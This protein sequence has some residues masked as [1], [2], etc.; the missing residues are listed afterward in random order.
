MRSSGI[1]FGAALAV[2]L[3]LVATASATPGDGHGGGRGRPGRATADLVNTGADEDASGRID[4]KHFPAVGRRVER[5]WLRFKVR[6]LDA[7][8]T[9]SLSMDDP[10][11][12]EDA[13]LVD[14]GIT[15]TTNDDGADNFRIDTKH[16]GT[17]P[18]GGTL[19]TLAGMNF[20]I[21]NGDGV[22]VLSG[23]VPAVQ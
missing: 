11:T 2:S 15:L 17:L 14:T 3:G 13:S 21:R 22:A 8:A 20:E 16:G 9:Y 18:F 5:S 10:S 19:A 1:V 7:N 6:H 4:V 12:A 23:A